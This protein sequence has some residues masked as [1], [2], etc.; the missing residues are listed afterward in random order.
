MWEVDKTDKMINY[1]G[2]NYLKCVLDICEDPEMKQRIMEMKDELETN[3][4]RR[5]A[6][7][8][9]RRNQNTRRYKCRS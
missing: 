7:L 9:H 1:F 3:K 6:D 8:Y 4:A 5:S 2:Y